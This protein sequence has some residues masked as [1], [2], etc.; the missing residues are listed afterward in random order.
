MCRQK[1]A[2]DVRVARPLEAADGRLEAAERLLGPVERPFALIAVVHHHFFGCLYIY[3]C[4]CENSKLSLKFKISIENIENTNGAK[5]TSL[6]K[7]FPHSLGNLMVPKFS[8][9]TLSW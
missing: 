5:R 4:S 9:I 6:Y 1:G 7:K 8:Y 3:F 2:E